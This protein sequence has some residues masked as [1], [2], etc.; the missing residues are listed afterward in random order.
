MGAIDRRACAI[1]LEQFQATHAPNTSV[2]LLPEQ[3]EET[4][5]HILWDRPCWATEEGE[6]MPSL[7]TAAAALPALG[8]VGHGLPAYG[9]HARCHLG[10][11]KA[12]M[13]G[14]WTNSPL[15]SMG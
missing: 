10:L 9:A 15:V 5:C 11:Q 8:P 7:Q 4:K 12:S 6:W 3:M 2:P 14:T 1:I 13:S